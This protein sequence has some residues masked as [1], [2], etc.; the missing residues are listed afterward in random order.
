MEKAKF[1]LEYYL[2][3]PSLSAVWVAVGT[4]AGM[5]EWFADD[6]WI[7]NDTKYVYLWDGHIQKAN[8]IDLKPYSY[9]RLQWEEDTG[10]DAC[11]ELKLIINELTKDMVLH[12]TDFALQNEINDSILVWNKQIEEMKRKNGL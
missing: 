5:A 11:F 4:P 1:E 10:T 2:K 12:I 3:S 6:V 7:E 8:V 9:I